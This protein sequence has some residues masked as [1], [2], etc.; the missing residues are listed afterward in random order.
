MYLFDEATSALDQYN[1]NL[2]QDAI[3]YISE[4]KTVIIVAHRKSSIE[5]CDR[6]IDINL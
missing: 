5:L 3:R 6:I 1:E 2:I 4:D